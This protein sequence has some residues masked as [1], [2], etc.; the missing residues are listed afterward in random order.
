MIAKPH[1][2][3]LSAL[4]LVPALWADP[5]S[6]AHPDPAQAASAAAAPATAELPVLVGATSRDKV[7]ATPEWVQAEVDAQ[8]DAAAAQALAAVEPGAE[9]TIYLGTWCGDSRREVP[10]FWKAVD[11]AGGSVPFEVRYVGVDHAKKEP[12][13]LLKQDGIRYLP[14]II[15]RRGGHEVGRIVE[16]SPHGVEQDLLA[17]LTGKATG[18]LSTR[19]DLSPATPQ[20]QG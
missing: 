12:A 18:V 8:P 1:L 11:A 17:L 16:T 20:P 7:E 3:A 10:R 9:V 6:V 4:L 13:D 15:V 5:P 2:L 19:Q 14:T